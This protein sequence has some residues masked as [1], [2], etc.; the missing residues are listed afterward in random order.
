MSLSL[1]DNESR[2]KPSVDAAMEEVENPFQVAQTIDP[3]VR[4]Y[5]YSLVTAV[6]ARRDFPILRMLTSL[7]LEEAAPKMT[8][9]M[10]SAM[11]H[12]LVCAI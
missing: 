3:E 1:D 9:A 2:A 4:A 7:S 6:S 11:T 10:C 5:V 8:V 12:W